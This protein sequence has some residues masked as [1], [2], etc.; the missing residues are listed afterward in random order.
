MLGTRQQPLEEEVKR[1]D[2]APRLAGL[3]PVLVV[4]AQTAAVVQPR[5]AALDDPPPR[6]HGE[7]LLIRR[8]LYHF[9]VNPVVVSQL[10]D[11]IV[12][13]IPAIGP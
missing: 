11:Q 9:K 4:F 6:L 7:A 10:A 5:N 2:V 1:T 3:S 8:L 13:A 12:T